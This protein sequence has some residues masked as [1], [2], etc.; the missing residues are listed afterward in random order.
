MNASVNVIDRA[1]A[2]FETF[3][4]IAKLAAMKESVPLPSH[5]ATS[6]HLTA[7]AGQESPA[8]IA[9]RTALRNMYLRMRLL[10]RRLIYIRTTFSTGG[11]NRR[12][13][14]LLHSS[15]DHS[16]ATPAAQQQVSITGEVETGRYSLQNGLPMHLSSR[17]FHLL[18]MN[19]MEEM[20]MEAILPRSLFLPYQNGL[21]VK[22]RGDLLKVLRERAT[23]RHMQL[24]HHHGWPWIAQRFGIPQVIPPGATV[25]GMTPEMIEEE[26]KKRRAEAEAAAAAAARIPTHARASSMRRRHSRGVSLLSGGLHLAKP[27]ESSRPSTAA[28]AKQH[29]RETSVASSVADRSRLGTARKGERKRQPSK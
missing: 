14:A 6:S 10:H 20:Q 17:W 1:Q 27:P 5:H 4:G 7:G 8:M 12:D 3:I 28:T 16:T 15:A 26:E 11:K 2:E 21:I 18:S 25:L 23:D 29:S 22:T 13:G 24:R 9:R 19:T